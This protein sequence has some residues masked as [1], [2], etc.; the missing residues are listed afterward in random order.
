MNPECVR[1]PWVH[2]LAKDVL[3]SAQQLQTA[4]YLAKNMAQ[5]FEVGFEEQFAEV[6]S[7]LSLQDSESC[8]SSKQHRSYKLVR[9]IIV[10]D[11][12]RPFCKS[13]LI[14]CEF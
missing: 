12:L 1:I 7:Q 6:E 5:R 8:E 9:W 3:L 13:F 2:P 4:M 14:N 10:F 11:Q